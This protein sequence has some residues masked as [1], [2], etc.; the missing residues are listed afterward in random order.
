MRSTPRNRPEP[1][2]GQ[3]APKSSATV[4][5]PHSAQLSVGTP[6]WL[7]TVPAVAIPDGDPV[8]SRGQLLAT[9]LVLQE[10]LGRLSAEQLADLHTALG[11]VVTGLRDQWSDTAPPEQTHIVDELDAISLSLRYRDQ[12]IEHATSD[13]A[14][15]ERTYTAV[16][17]RCEHFPIDTGTPCPQCKT[18]QWVTAVR[19]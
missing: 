11:T 15:S 13:T 17:M 14:A 3:V 7:A 19:S 16:C 5:T 10:A 4:E 2:S 12:P 18:D 9:R 1:H 6:P 8:Q